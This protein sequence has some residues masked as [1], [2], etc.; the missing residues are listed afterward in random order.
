M[1]DTPNDGVPD[2]LANTTGEAPTMPTPA[3]TLAAPAEAVAATAAEPEPETVRIRNPDNPEQWVDI[4]KIDGPQPKLPEPSP[5]ETAA[6][7]DVLIKFKRFWQTNPRTSDEQ[8]TAL[9]CAEYLV[10][11]VKYAN[12]P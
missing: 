6:V 10:G 4:R 11:L 3:F 1:S 5:M 8:E 7:A 9:E 12:Q 2:W